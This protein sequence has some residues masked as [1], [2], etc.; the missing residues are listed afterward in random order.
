[1]SRRINKIVDAI[2]TVSIQTNMLAV[3]GSSRPCRRIWQGLCRG[4]DRHPAQD[5][6]ENADRIK[7]LVKAV[8]D[9]ISVVGRDLDEIVATA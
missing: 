8:Q 5:S 2:A 4:G 3:D 6:A 7:D 1:M 9:Q